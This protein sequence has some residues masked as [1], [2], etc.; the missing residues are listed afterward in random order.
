M[1]MKVQC[2]FRQS[3]L[4]ATLLCTINSGCL[5]DPAAPL[6]DNPTSVTNGSEKISR[7]FEMRFVLSDPKADA[8][9]TGPKTGAGQYL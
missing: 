6:S 1:T 5:T 9:Q 4:A 2:S 3:L 7:A 8:R